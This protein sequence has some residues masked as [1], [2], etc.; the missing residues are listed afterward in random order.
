MEI[1]PDVITTHYEPKSIYY[2]R[3]LQTG[4][5]YLPISQLILYPFEP[6][7]GPLPS[8]SL[9]DEPTYAQSFR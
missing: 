5:R 2:Q 1:G 8:H 6:E 3:Y 7:P 9:H 4:K